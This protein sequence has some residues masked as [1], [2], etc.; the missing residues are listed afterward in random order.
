MT[1]AA[2]EALGDLNLGPPSAEDKTETKGRQ[3]G[4]VRWFN[5]SKGFGFIQ[6]KDVHAEASEGYDL[7]C[8]QTSIKAEGFRS[9]MEGESVEFDLEVGDDGRNKA[10]NVT[11]PRGAPPQGAPRRS[12][13]HISRRQHPSQQHQQSQCMPPPQHLAHSH[14]LGGMQ[15]GIPPNQMVQPGSAMYSMQA[16]SGAEF[17]HQHHQHHQQQPLGPHQ[18]SRSQ[19]HQHLQHWTQGGLTPGMYSLS[20]QQQQQQQPQYS[21]GTAGYLSSMPENQIQRMQGNLPPAGYYN[22]RSAMPMNS[23]SGTQWFGNRMA[24]GPPPPQPHQHQQHHPQHPT[25]MLHQQPHGSSSRG[26]TAPGG[27]VADRRPPPGTPGVSSGLQVV[28]HNLPWSISEEQLAKAFTENGSP[29]VER[30]SIIV[31][32]SGGSRGFGTVLF[33]SSK[34]AETAVEVMNNADVGGRAVT[35]RIDRFA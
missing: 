25:M 12:P 17:P 16:G 11:G 1:D 4:S 30:A 7:F 23:L 28:V 24:V 13:M 26:M 14:T 18:Q 5:A 34:D 20:M 31:D 2:A 29:P 35:V 22:G 3:Q 27:G 10:V 33:K 8:H 6:P 21:L 19:Q 15:M 32:S 9:L